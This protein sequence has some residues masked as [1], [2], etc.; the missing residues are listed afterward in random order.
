MI[1]KRI[2]AFALIVYSYSY[3]CAGHIVTIHNHNFYPIYAAAYDVK[4]TIE[5]ANFVSATRQSSVVKVTAHGKGTIERPE[6]HV[7]NHRELFLTIKG[8]DLTE[9]I[10]H[11]DYTKMIKY[12]IGSLNSSICHVAEEDNNLKGYSPIE[13]YIVEPIF[14]GLHKITHKAIA[15][16]QKEYSAY[17]YT[18]RDAHVKFDASLSQEEQQTIANRRTYV[19]KAIS[20]I[21]G[22]QVPQENAPCIAVSL[23]GGGMRAAICDYGLLAGLQDINMIDTITYIAAISG[24]TWFLTDWLSFDSDFANYNE[25]FMQVLT[26][27]HRYS[28]ET[29]SRQLLRK[30]IFEQDQGIADLYGTFLASTFFSQEKNPDSIVFSSIAQKVQDGTWPFP[31]CTFIET[32]AERHWLTCTPYDVMSETLN[33]CMPIWSFGRKFVNG[34]STDRAPEYPLGYF[35]GMWGSA[36]SGSISDMYEA[37]TSHEDSAIKKII[38]SILLNINLADYRPAG[39]YLHNPLYGLQDSSH[40]NIKNF[41]VMD[42]GYACNLPTLPV[43]HPQRNADI[44]IILD[45]TD[46]V[47]SH[48]TELERAEELAHQY[49]K[50]F[51][52]IDYDKIGNNALTIFTD[53]HNHDCPAVVYIFPAK[54]DAYDPKFNPAKIFSTIYSAARFI[55]TRHEID[56]LAGLVQFIISSHKQELYELIKQK[57]FIRA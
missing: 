36:L 22:S 7:L 25:H 3:I 32:S 47:H 19:S 6:S 9:Q 57:S 40:R 33:F 53:P 56:K 50:L 13:W 45:V 1:V 5:G 44:I 10:A 15:L 29:L 55:Y 54:D 41:T 51:P 20:Q 11:D 18:D 27:S 4:K 42:A 37:I 30:Y 48:H 24:G 12:H 39:M 16:L 26:H 2:L 52:P 46:G 49:G 23:S 8:S 17:P 38:L 31:L 21:T 34:I 28:S 14:N 35:M 43:L